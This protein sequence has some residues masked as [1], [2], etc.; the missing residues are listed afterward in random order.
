MYSAALLDPRTGAPLPPK[1]METILAFQRE[2]EAANQTELSVEDQFKGRYAGNGT[3][4]TFPTLLSPVDISRICTALSFRPCPTCPDSPPVLDGGGGVFVLISSCKPATDGTNLWHGAFL[5]A[6]YGV[7]DQARPS[8]RFSVLLEHSHHMIHVRVA[9][10]QIRD[11][12]PVVLPR[13]AL[14]AP[15][16]VFVP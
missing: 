8:L 11:K 1:C 6:A 15:P 3:D 13:Q 14:G 2:G 4:D 5:L 9:R 16:I 10:T 12:V 7:R